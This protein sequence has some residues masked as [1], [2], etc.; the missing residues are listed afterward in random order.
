MACTSATASSLGASS[1]ATPES[2]V[3]TALV[4]LVS[5]RPVMPVPLPFR[6]M[7]SS[8]VP[9]LGHK[10]AR[11]KRMFERVSTRAV[12]RATQWYVRSN[13]RVYDGQRFDSLSEEGPW[14]T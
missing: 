4:S 12:S 10:A 1:V 13:E 5:S 6:Q 8:A 11:L 9:T 3:S 14:V 7:F 2:A